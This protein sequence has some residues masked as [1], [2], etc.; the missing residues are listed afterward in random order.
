LRVKAWVSF[1]C[2]TCIAVTAVDVTRAVHLQ[3]IAVAG[4]NLSQSLSRPRCCSCTAIIAADTWTVHLQAGN[5]IPGL[6]CACLAWLM[7]S[8]SSPLQG[9][10]NRRHCRHARVPGRWL[11]S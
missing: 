9:L 4:N 2:C 1:V 6:L 10:T 5:T 8:Q 7:M 3:P 11:S